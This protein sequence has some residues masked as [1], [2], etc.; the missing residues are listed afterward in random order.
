MSIRRYSPEKTTK[1]LIINPLLNNDNGKQDNCNKEAYYRL[2]LYLLADFE[3]ISNEIHSTS[4]ERIYKT[5]LQLF[6]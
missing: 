3:S 4:K 6:K 1:T 2:Y 5:D